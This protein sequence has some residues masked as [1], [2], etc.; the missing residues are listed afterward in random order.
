MHSCSI[1]N[2]NENK[3]SSKRKIITQVKEQGKWE[4]VFEHDSWVSRRSPKVGK[5]NLLKGGP[6]KKCDSTSVI[7]PSLVV[8]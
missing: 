4:L 5:T 3:D 8:G 2:D 7:A 1:D 6:K